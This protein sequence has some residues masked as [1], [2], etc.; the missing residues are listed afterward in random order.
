MSMT[1]DADHELEL[2]VT[3]DRRWLAIARASELEGKG[4]YQTRLVGSE[5]L[6]V[7]RNGVGDL[8]AHLNS[9]RHRGSQILQG[10]GRVKGLMCPYHGWMYSLDGELRGAPEMKYTE[11]F[12]KAQFPLISFQA[13]EWAGFAWVAL[14]PV[15]TTPE[16]A[17]IGTAVVEEL[18]SAVC[19]RSQVSDADGNWQ[20]VLASVA[21][22]FAAS[23][24]LS[25]GGD[26]LVGAEH[27]AGVESALL[28]RPSLLLVRHSGGWTSLSV[29]PGP[30]GRAQLISNDLVPTAA[31][32]VGDDDLV[33]PADAPSARSGSLVDLDPGTGGGPGS[34]AVSAA[35]RQWHEADRRARAAC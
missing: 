22:R 16:Q 27:P 6:I 28:V 3:F 20:D 12:D 10:A 1:A 7:L 19:T 21:G 24:T 25:P 18:S 15:A 9:C 31:E 23:W 14:A 8:R 29:V 5:P 13:T 11:C 2:E 26:V 34:T 30:D 33:A 35:L 17:D 4:S 32:G